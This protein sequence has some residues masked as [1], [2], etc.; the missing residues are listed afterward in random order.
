MRDR[1][2]EDWNLSLLQ[3]VGVQW[4][5]IA[6]TA[7][8]IAGGPVILESLLSCRSV[9]TCT[10]YF[11]HSR[12]QS[13]PSNPSPL[14]FRRDRMNGKRVS[15][16]KAVPNHRSAWARCVLLFKFISLQFFFVLVR[17]VRFL[18]NIHFLPLEHAL[19]RPRNRWTAIC[20][21]IVDLRCREMRGHHKEQLHYY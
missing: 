14:Y 6:V 9:E 8:P 5:H 4:E 7:G 12:V 17:T 21:M 15:Q 11:K 20:D 18:A 10:V 16:D 13:E 19:K 2:S 3:V 1:L